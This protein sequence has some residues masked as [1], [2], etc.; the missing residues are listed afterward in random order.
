MSAETIDWLL[1]GPHP[2][3]WQVLR[4]LTDASDDEVRAEQVKAT[5]QGLVPELLNAQRPDGT[6]GGIAWNPGFDSTMHALSLLREFG[7]LPEH[8]TVQRALERVCANVTWNGCGPPE[9]AQNRFFEGETEACINGQVA[10]AGAYLGCEVHGLVNRLIGEQLP[11]GGWNCEVEYGSTRSSF[12]STLCVLEALLAYETR[13]G[14]NEASHRARRIGEKY[15]LDR[16]L[17]RRLSTGEPIGHDR[18]SGID[19]TH[20][21]FPTW[22]HYDLL[23]ALDYLRAAGQRPSPF[24]SEAVD[25]LKSRQRPDGRWNLETRLSGPTPVELGGQIGEPDPFVTLRALRVL[26]WAES[27]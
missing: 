5:E 13:F 20:P 24:T 3:R 19:W 17:H 27:S 6:W 8:T 18:R 1:A 22:W 15:L 12:N 11:D 7:A 25:I 9:C 23:R 4:D 2:V 14:P 26:K 10:S 21:A 16:H